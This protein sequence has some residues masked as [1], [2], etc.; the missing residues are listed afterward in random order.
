MS[1]KGMKKI[2]FIVL[3][4][5]T[6]NIFAEGIPDKIWIDGEIFLYVKINEFN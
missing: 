4:L 2:I 1:A 5:L 6:S 3:M